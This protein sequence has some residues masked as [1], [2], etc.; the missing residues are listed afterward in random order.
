MRLVV[1]LRNPGS[2]FEGSRHNIGGE[3]LEGLAELHQLTFR[4]APRGIRAD[5]IETPFDEV[6]VVL[7]IPR[8]YM[9]ESGQ[10]IA[11][12]LRYFG[13]STED[14]LLVH[15]DIDLA[16]ATLRVQFGRGA[17]GNNGVQSTIQALRSQEFWRLRVGVGRPPGQMDP[18]D[19]VLS[20]FTKAERAEM[21][22][23]VRLAV[24]IV[25]SFIAEGG[26]RARQEAGEVNRAGTE[27]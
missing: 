14:L 8:T 4:R 12:L 7:A 27:K 16:F 25:A 13:V 23:V 26:E 20:R 6:R 17:G 10:A 1:G 9:N 11:P 22:L 15:D 19:H 3:V 2:R 5:V 21:D 18:A 24:D